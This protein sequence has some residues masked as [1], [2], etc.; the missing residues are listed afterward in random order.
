MN[1]DVPVAVNG[2]DKAKPF[3]GV[4]P[5]DRSL[6]FQLLTASGD[7]RS[8]AAAVWG[9]SRNGLADFQHLRDL[10]SSRGFFNP[11]LEARSFGD[12]AAAGGFQN[13]HVQ[14]DFGAILELDEAKT[15]A[16][17]E[18]D[19]LSVDGIHRDDGRALK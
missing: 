11:D 16:G 13:A 6:A 15:L 17:V 7:S 3:V 5:F 19:H 8:A 2:R 18:P 4:V 1:E 12:V 10:A 9:N 14:V